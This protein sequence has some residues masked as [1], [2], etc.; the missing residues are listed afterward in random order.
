MDGGAHIL[1]YDGVCGLCNRLVR[2]ILARDRRRRFQFAPL[3]SALAAETLA[4][5]GR[6]PRDLDTVYLLADG[7]LLNKSRAILGVL[8]TLGGPWSLAAVLGWLPT[9]L[10]DWL[11]VRVARNRYRLFGRY[12]SCRLPSAEERSRFLGL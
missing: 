6:D 5:F 10:L 3:Q 2:F 8:R 1:F 11:Y 9:A 12:E 7:E 4:R